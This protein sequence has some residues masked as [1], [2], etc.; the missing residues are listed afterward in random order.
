MRRFHEDAHNHRED[1]AQR[2][3][4][5]HRLQR[6]DHTRFRGSLGL[7]GV[8]ALVGTDFILTRRI[9]LANIC[10]LVQQLRERERQPLTH[11]EPIGQPGPR[12]RP[13]GWRR[14]HGRIPGHPALRPRRSGGAGRRREHRLPQ[15]AHQKALVIRRCPWKMRLALK[16]GPPAENV[17]RSYPMANSVSIDNPA[18]LA[19]IKGY[20]STIA[21]F[22]M[23]LC[24]DLVLA[25]DQL[26]V[27]AMDRE[28]ST[29]S[30]SESYLIG[31]EWHS[32]G[33]DLGYPVYGAFIR[34]TAYARCR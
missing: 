17:A 5:R 14:R 21:Q 7:H 2:E 29:A 9:H 32:M 34:K 6:H 30:I 1:R 20:A 27:H 24:E 13:G 10:F 11:T 19:R 26:Y 8:D 33:C 4:G 31:V 18:R 12:R 15:K 3:V 28:D 16:S 23:V 22:S 25:V